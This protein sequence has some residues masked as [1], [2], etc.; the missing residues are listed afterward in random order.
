MM[1]RT[2]RYYLVIKNKILN[3][4]Y[5]SWNRT[6]L[7]SRKFKATLHSTELENHLHFQKTATT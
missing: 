6:K 2:E 3:H 4:V 7:T 5:R 1:G